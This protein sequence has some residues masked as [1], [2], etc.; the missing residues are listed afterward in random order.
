[1]VIQ[2]RQLIWGLSQGYVSWTEASTEGRVD[3]VWRHM[4]GSK[5]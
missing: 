2:V 4:E 3:V 5:G 1:M